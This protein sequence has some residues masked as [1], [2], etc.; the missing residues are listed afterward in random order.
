MHLLGVGRF[1]AV[2]LGHFSKVSATLW[3]R[4]LVPPAATVSWNPVGVS[5]MHVRRA[6]VLHFQGS[7]LKK[8]RKR[9]FPFPPS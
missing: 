7:A 8:S 2:N 6:H 1:A 5:S 3:G 9:P 4:R